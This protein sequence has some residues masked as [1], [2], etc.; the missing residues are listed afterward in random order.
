MGVLLGALGVFSDW[1]LEDLGIAYD[2]HYFPIAAASLAAILFGTGPGVTAAVVGSL[3]EDFFLVEPVG[4]VLNTP[5]SI[6]LFALN[7]AMALAIASLVGALREAIADADRLRLEAER[8]SEM[9]RNVLS[10][11]AHDL[12][13]PLTSVRLQTQILERMLGQDATPE[14]I[15]PAVAALD[16]TTARAQRL[17]AELFDAMKLQFGVFQVT[18]RPTPARDLLR[19]VVELHGAI[20][21]QKQVALAVADGAGLPEVRADRAEQVLANLVANAIEHTPAG[22]HVEVA[23]QVEGDEVRFAVSDEGPGI[24]PADR[25]RLF[26]RFWQGGRGAGAGLG[27]YIAKGI[28]EA[29]QGRIGVATAPGEGSRFWFTLPVVEREEPV[30]G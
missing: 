25:D 18:P 8:M 30:P 7:L 5:S 3:G 10:I 12:R 24:E 27:L 14:R 29:N 16:R 13:G 1:L 2:L 20:A 17:V 19:G 15:R 6:V 4:S 22:G 9:R 21:A 11:V 28:V 26:T 23:A